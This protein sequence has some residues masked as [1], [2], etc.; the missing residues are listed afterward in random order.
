V[1]VGINVM[2][3]LMKTTDKRFWEIGNINHQRQLIV[4]NMEKKITAHQTNAQS[5][6]Q[7][8]YCYLLSNEHGRHKV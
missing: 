1:D 3:S 7:L 2:S 6:R 5:K 8:T 4:D